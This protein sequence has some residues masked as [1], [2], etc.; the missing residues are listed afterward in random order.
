[1]AYDGL[2]FRGMGCHA[3][4]TGNVY[5]IW[6]YKS[7]LYCFCICPSS[8]DV[9]VHG[10]SCWKTN[11]TNYRGPF[12]L[13]QI[14][15]LNRLIPLAVWAADEP[16]AS[17]LVSALLECNWRTSL[18]N[19]LISLKK[20]SIQL[21]YPLLRDLILPAYISYGSSCGTELC[22]ELYLINIFNQLLMFT[23]YA[24]WY[25]ACVY[26]MLYIISNIKNTISQS[27]N[28]HFACMWIFIYK[29]VVSH[30]FVS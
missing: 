15:I 26:F 5:L 22:T 4:D 28:M 20:S 9:S 2:S 24:L 3:P 25:L 8:Y 27:I 19:Y 14:Y 30:C 18:R 1:M 7:I 12:F 21:W 11:W 23:L 6:N 13:Y 16:L 29:L 10:H 17:C